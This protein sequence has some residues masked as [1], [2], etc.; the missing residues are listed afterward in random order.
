M[1][2]SDEFFLQIQVDL[3]IVTGIA[4]LGEDLLW[5]DLLTDVLALLVADDDPPV[6]FLAL[7]YI[8]RDITIH[9]K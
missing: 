6:L 1:W 5:F 4:S 9:I 3:P 2:M 7:H 8:H